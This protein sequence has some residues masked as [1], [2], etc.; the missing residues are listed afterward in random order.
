MKKKVLLT[1]GIISLIVVNMELSFAS[2]PNVIE[3]SETIDYSVSEDYLN[4]IDKTIS[5]NGKRYELQNI[6][7][8]DNLKTEEKHYEYIEQK[9][10][11]TDN[12]SLI[13]KFFEQTKNVEDDGFKGV[14]N[15]ADSTLEIVPRDSYKEEYKV[16]LQRN[17]KN[18]SSNELNNIPKEIQENGTT[19]FL[20]NP[21]WN[22]TDVELVDGKEVP[23]KYN[24]TMNYEGKKTI[25][26]VTSYLSKIKYTGTIEKKVND[27]TTF[28]AKYKEIE[29]IKPEKNK[30]NNSID[31]PKAVVG[32]S[33]IIF[34]CGI[35][36]FRSKNVKIYNLQKDG[37]YKLIKKV[38]LN[39]KDMLID[40][41][42]YSYQ[43]RSYKIV[44]SNLLFK[45]I[46]GKNVKFKYFD[47]QY[48][49]N[50]QNKEFE[51]LV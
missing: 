8:K 38:H 42:P 15:M 37:A 33:S 11:G 1:L 5:E 14:V 31:I 50:I 24:G 29:N 41:T 40:L 20:V 13:L 47:K 34:I 19:Y 48:N 17:Y 7:K 26:I 16:Y 21:V 18:V 49:Y 25:T 46:K 6:D 10:V 23:I 12:K 28:T 27:T 22:V 51:V 45:K 30:D 39:N 4:S 32:T 9:V 3:K 44:I 43:S 2:N 36:I 35:V